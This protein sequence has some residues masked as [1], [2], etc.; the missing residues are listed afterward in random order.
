MIKEFTIVF[1]SLFAQPTATPPAVP[2]PVVMKARVATAPTA[3]EILSGVQKFY[4]GIS[5]VNAKFRQEVVNTTFGRSDIS[6]GYVRIQ[7][8]GKMRWE[9][10]AKKQ[11]GKPRTI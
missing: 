7:K 5:G 1:G 9:Y 4:A 6:D 10:W 11:R 3:A 2:T 8:P